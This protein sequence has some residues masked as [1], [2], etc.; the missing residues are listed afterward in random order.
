MVI[1]V[2]LVEHERWVRW[3]CVLDNRFERCDP[4]RD[5]HLLLRV[6]SHQRH[7]VEIPADKVPDG[8]VRTDEL[9]SWMAVVRWMHHLPQKH[10]K[11][12]L[13]LHYESVS[14]LCPVLRGVLRDGWQETQ[15]G[16]QGNQG[17]RQETVNL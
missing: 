9:T 15:E 13:V 4:H 6:S 11:C 8:S 17:C 1:A 7:L 5:V 12:L 16:E 2:L 3:R 10:H 14:P